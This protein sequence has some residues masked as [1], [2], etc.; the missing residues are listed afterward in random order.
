MYPGHHFHQEL[1]RARYADM[2]REARAIKIEAA[3]KA[4]LAPSGR[5]RRSFARRPRFVPRPVA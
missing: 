2:L 5:L 4:D 3:L 1:A